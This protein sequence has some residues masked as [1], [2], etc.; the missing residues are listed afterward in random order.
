MPL[1]DE[2]VDLVPDP[3]A[4]DGPGG[5]PTGPGRGTPAA[6]LP[7]LAATLAAALTMAA[8]SGCVEKARRQAGRPR[9]PTISQ[10][11]DGS[12]EAAPDRG[13]RATDTAAARDGGRSREPDRT[14]L[15]AGTSQGT[16]ISPIGRVPP[17]ARPATNAPTWPG[18]P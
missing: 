16:A 5:G 8:F 4:P 7:M 12:T 2:I 11:A 15:S 18:I 13:G 9:N 10:T 17:A 6:S 3:R 14:T 1:P